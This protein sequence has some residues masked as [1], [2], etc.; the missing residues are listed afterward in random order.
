MPFQLDSHEKATDDRSL[1]QPG[2]AYAQTRMKAY[3]LANMPKLHQLTKAVEK[4]RNIDHFNIGAHCVLY[5]DNRVSSGD[6]RIKRR[7]R[8]LLT[9]PSACADPTFSQDSMGDHADDDQGEEVVFCAVIH[10]AMPRKVRINV[11]KRLAQNNGK[12]PH[13]EGDEIIE[14]FLK[15]GDCYEMDDIMQQSYSHCIPKVTVKSEF[16]CH[17]EVMSPEEQRRRFERISVV[18]RKGQER[19][20]ERDNGHL[21]ENLM[22]SQPVTYTFGQIR[23]EFGDNAFFA[24]LNSILLMLQHSDCHR[25][26]REWRVQQK[27]VERNGRL[28]AVASRY[29]WSITPRC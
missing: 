26:R 15:T 16:G 4:D 28:S 27:A 17:E 9:F 7:P 11:M 14:L 13:Q 10:C 18:L 8:L 22:P 20:F 5:R 25:S 12:A 2:Y 19:F 23:G 29:Q 21:V 6:Q 24:L 1:P 3:P